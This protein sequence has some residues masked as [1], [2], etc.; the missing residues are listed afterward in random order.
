MK[1]VMDLNLNDD[2]MKNPPVVPPGQAFRKGWRIE[3]T[4]TCTW[5][6]SYKLTYDG[7]N[8]SASSMGGQPTPI[9]GT[10]APGAQYDIWVDLV[11]PAVPGVYQGFWVLRN[12]QDQKFGDRIWVGIR[13]PS[14]PT[15]TPSPTQTPSP[16]IAFK[17][18][19]DQPVSLPEI[20]SHLVGL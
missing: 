8:S 16:G 10:V 9:V 19:P 17:V 11:A 3:N 2:N 12:A 1:F 5:N 13:V 20:V 4:G 15:V 7:G 18:D 6:S 14:P